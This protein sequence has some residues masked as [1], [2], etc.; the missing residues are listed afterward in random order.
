MSARRTGL[1]RGL[2][3]LLGDAS[4]PARPVQTEPREGLRHIPVELLQRGEYQP[5]QDMDPAALEDLA[6][7]IKAQGLVQPIV[8]RPLPASTAAGEVRYE[9]IAGERRWRAAQMAGLATVPAVV[10][11]IP[12]SAVIAQALIENIQRENLNPLE[13]AQAVQRLI[14]EFQLTHQEAADAIGRSRA[15]VSNLLR[16][17]ELGEQARTLLRSGALEMGHARALLGLTDP[18]MQAEV[19]SLVAKKGLSVRET[20]AL[21]RRVQAG[22]ATQGGDRPRAVDPDVQRL[23]HELSD[24]LGARVQIQHGS[25][26]R[27][28]LVVNYT[29]LDELDGIIA[30]IQ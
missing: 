27:G 1:G 2:D 19:A 22:G 17:L 12:D 9:I 24:R 13:E 16:L 14:G 10:R 3:A 8:V 5:R 21:V 20:E 4:P 7:S 25:K 23:E 26:G 29:S 18:R 30:H 28:K 11:Q 6:R 15:A